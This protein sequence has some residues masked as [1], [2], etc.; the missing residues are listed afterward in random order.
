[1]KK[2]VYLKT[3]DVFFVRID[4][5]NKRYFQYIANDL[6][7]LNSDVIRAFEKKYPVDTLPDLDKVLNDK[8]IFYAH[9]IV[10]IGVKLGYWEKEGNSSDVGTFDHILFRR[11]SDY[12]QRKGETPIQISQNWYVWRI[13]DL[14][15]SFVGK[16]EGENRTA[17]I[18][19]VMDPESIVH[20]LRT[21]EYGGFYP[22][23]E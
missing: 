12:G 23:F 19:V 13:N 22:G 4:D 6:T 16:L 11:A 15:F 5:E 1:M 17:D 7:L 18:G 3:G 21:G 20:R 2:R 8:I 10:K 9:C 14:N